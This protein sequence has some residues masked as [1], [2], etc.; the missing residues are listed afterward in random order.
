[1]IFASILSCFKG[2]DCNEILYLDLNDTVDINKKTA[3]FIT[4]LQLIDDRCI[5]FI[6]SL[7]ISI[8][9][10]LQITV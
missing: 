7:Y 2:A 6:E 10:K 9:T 3:A 5:Y 1:M 4:D 8:Y